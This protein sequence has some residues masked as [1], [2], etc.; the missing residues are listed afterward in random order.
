[1]QP[2]TEWWNVNVSAPHLELHHLT[3]PDGAC[4]RLNS[5]GVPYEELAC[6]YPW[7]KHA[8][9]IT[10]WEERVDFFWIRDWMRQTLWWYPAVCVG[11]YLGMV[12]F[13]PLL[14]AK[15]SPLNLRGTWAGWNFALS[16]F[17]LIGFVRTFPALVHYMLTNRSY[18]DWYCVD[19]ETTCGSGSTGLWALLWVLSKVP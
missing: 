5:A 19:P 6:L 9:F 1:M 11:L 2:A 13:L 8:A 12:F 3:R 7:L 10:N 18:T 14:F 15:R 17:S 4:V 16:A